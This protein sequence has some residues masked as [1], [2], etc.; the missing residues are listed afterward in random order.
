LYGDTKVKRIIIGL[1]ASGKTTLYRKLNEEKQAFAVEIELPQSCVNDEELKYNLFR[2]FY[3]NNNIDVIIVHPYYLTN[4]FIEFLSPDDTVEFLNVP[5]EERKRR[6]NERSKSY[7][8]DCVIFDGDFYEKEEQA[9]SKLKREV[10][11]NDIH[12]RRM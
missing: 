10:N 6:A 8:A 7:N 3:E 11:C 2:L 5:I 1:V 9:L 12:F 4:R